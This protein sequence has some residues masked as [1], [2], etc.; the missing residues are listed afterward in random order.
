[1]LN[2]FEHDSYYTKA[3][4]MKNKHRNNAPETTAVGHHHTGALN[5]GEKVKICKKHQTFEVIKLFC[6]SSYVLYPNNVLSSV[7][8]YI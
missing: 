5:S 2:A 3:M 4:L 8:K 6:I 1:M 7:L